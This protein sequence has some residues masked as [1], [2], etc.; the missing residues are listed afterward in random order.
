[1]VD[2]NRRRMIQIGGI[3]VGS[4][5]G[6]G[7]GMAKSE[8]NTGLA[9][10]GDASDPISKSEIFSRRSQ[11]INKHLDYS[12]INNGVVSNPKT[13]EN[14][15]IVAYNLDFVGEGIDEYFGIVS[16]ETGDKAISGSDN[17]ENSVQKI[18]KRANNKK[19]KSFK[20][21]A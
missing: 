11:E 1:M 5:V 7:I 20:R 18:H 14:D 17:S 4:I 13:P 15:I 21:R 8:S 16:S 6:S 19:N 10:R 3:A 12:T 9:L 2:N